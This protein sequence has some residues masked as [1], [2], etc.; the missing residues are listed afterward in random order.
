MGCKWHKNA[1]IIL[2][3]ILAFCCSMVTTEERTYL[4]SCKALIEEG[5]E[6]AQILKEKDELEQQLSDK[7]G[8]L[9]RKQSHI[10]QLMDCNCRLK[11]ACEKKRFTPQKEP[12]SATP[13]KTP[14]K[15]TSEHQSKPHPNASL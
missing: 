12:T 9:K 11:L 13:I 10:E 1:Q 2:I 5:Q 8:Q 15:P 4:K 7:T 3:Y 14:S 6:L